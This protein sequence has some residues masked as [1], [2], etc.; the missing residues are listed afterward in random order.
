[1]RTRIK[2]EPL[3]GTSSTILTG[4]YSNKDHNIVVMDTH[5]EIHQGEL[6]KNRKQF[7]FTIRP[8]S[9]YVFDLDLSD[10]VAQKRLEFWENHP[11]IEVSGKTNPNLVKPIFRLS[12]LK[13]VE[14]M[15]NVS[16]H[17]RFKIAEKIL[18]F[19]DV[20]LD[21]IIFV[22]NGDPRDF[23]DRGSKENFLIGSDF[24]SGRAMMYDTKFNMYTSISPEEQRVHNYVNKAIRLGVIPMMEGVFVYAGK[25]IGKTPDEVVHYFMGD[26]E[27]FEG[28]IVNAVNEINLPSTEEKPKRTPGRKA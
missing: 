13:E 28:G 9:N 3:S 26:T 17:Q 15:K 24:I 5:G 19:N 10:K 8:R 20:E 27:A 23:V 25:N 21:N 11:N 6:P 14:A 7:T 1:M 4:S 18:N 2:I 22:L 16:I 12:N